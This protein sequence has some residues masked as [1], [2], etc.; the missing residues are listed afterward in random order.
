M[1][2]APADAVAAVLSIVGG[3]ACALLLGGMD[4]FAGIFARTASSQLPQATATSFFSAAF[5]AYYVVMEAFGAV[6]A[7]SLACV[8]PHHGPLSGWKGQSWV[9]DIVFTAV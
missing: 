6:A 7:P 1:P 8:R 5:S 9:W 3:L 4:T 2:E